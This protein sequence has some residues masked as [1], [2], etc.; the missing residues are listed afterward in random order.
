MFLYFCRMTRA[1]E[2]VLAIPF[3]D[4]RFTTPPQYFYWDRDYRWQPPPLPDY[5]LWCIMEG[6]GTVSLRGA[7]YSLTPGC[8][9]FL[10]PG[11]KP[12]ARHDPRHPLVAF[13]C[14]FHLF[15][16][17]GRRIRPRSLRIPPPALQARDMGLLSSLANRCVAN[18]RR[19]EPLGQRQARVV[20]EEMLLLVWEWAF[21]PAPHASDSRFGDIMRAVER[22]PGNPWS[23]QEMA[24][25]GN[26]SNSQ[27]TRRFTAMVGMPPM[28]FVIRARLNTARQLVRETD[29]KLAQIASE[30]GYADVYFFSRQFKQRFGR[31]PSDLRPKK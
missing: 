28:E 9:F 5:D 24:R 12:D 16:R 25:M 23:V 13:F 14:H 11:D 1:K 6:R 7:E 8:C 10:V 19:G 29:M 17:R 30:L 31:P 18:Y 20:L 4:L 27:F 15:D 26:L 22:K 3:A 21:T 2:R